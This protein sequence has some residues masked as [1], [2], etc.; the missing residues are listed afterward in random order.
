MYEEAD[1]KGDFDN[2]ETLDDLKIPELKIPLSAK[3]TFKKKFSP[4]KSRKLEMDTY[5]DCGKML[6][7]VK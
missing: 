4:I 3:K 2:L 5:S 7:K 6:K 1:L